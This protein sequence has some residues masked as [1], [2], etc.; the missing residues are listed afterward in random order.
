MTEAPPTTLREGFERYLDMIID[1]Q[2][3]HF[4]KKPLHP[5]RWFRDNM[6]QCTVPGRTKRMQKQRCINNSITTCGTEPEATY[7]EGFYYKFIPITHAWNQ[8][9]DGTFVDNT[10]LIRNRSQDAYFGVR[11]PMM[12]ILMAASNKHWMIHT[13]VLETMSTFD[14]DL[15]AYA[16]ELLEEDL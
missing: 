12:L 10:L 4:E 16:K 2:A 7:W 8:L 5:M 3:K 9:S 15:L 1:I 6:V 11:I 14:D 13:G